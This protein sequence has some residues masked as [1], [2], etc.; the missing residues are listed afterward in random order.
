MNNIQKFEELA[1]RL[2]EGTFER[3]F[4]AKLH[5]GDIARR[6]AVT[7]DE[8]S[9]PDEEGHV[10]IPSTYEVRLNPDDYIALSG[11]MGSIDTTLEQL[12]YYLEQLAYE[13]GFYLY[14]EIDLTISY[15]E[16]VE[17]GQI[18]VSA[19]Y[20]VEDDGSTFVL[21]TGG[22]HEADT[23]DMPPLARAS[24]WC[25]VVDGKE[26]RLGEPL[27]NLGRALD[28]DIII[29][30]LSVSRHHARLRW[31]GDAYEIRD[32]GSS[33]GTF[34]NGER[35]ELGTLKPGDVVSL[36]SLEVKVKVS[37]NPLKR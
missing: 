35:G 34:L 26:I 23:Q 12:Q 6:L 36:G 19:S 15:D 25:L 18:E 1:E 7:M 29:D 17:P 28:N 3:I 20:G 24:A 33:L 27:L 13:G 5:P 16:K 22:I 32:L 31:T 14:D 2:I 8:K 9:A 37:E 10:V 21:E 4:G 11:E 30:D